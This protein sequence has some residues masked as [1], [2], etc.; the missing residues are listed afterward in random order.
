MVSVGCLLFI[1]LLTV[2][3]EQMWADF[4]LINHKICLNPL[5][6]KF[7]IVY[8]GNT[9]Y[10]LDILLVT[11]AF[12]CF[13]IAISSLLVFRKCL[14]GI[15]NRTLAILVEIFYDFPQFLQENTWNMSHAN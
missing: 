11:D 1:L 2:R 14:L 4:Q 9:K 3:D 13:T 10:I 8:Y 12:A 5:S 7:F 15:S 6:C